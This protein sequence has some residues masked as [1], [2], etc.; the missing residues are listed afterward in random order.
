MFE[1]SEFKDPNKGKTAPY[2]GVSISKDKIISF[3]NMDYVKE[4]HAKT[5]CL[6]SFDFDEMR[7]ADRGGANCTGLCINSGNSCPHRI[8][9]TTYCLTLDEC[10]W[11]RIPITFDQAKAADIQVKTFHEQAAEVSDR[12]R[13]AMG[14][15]YRKGDRV[16]VTFPRRFPPTCAVILTKDFEYGQQELHAIHDDEP[17]L[18]QSQHWER[19]DDAST[20]NGLFKVQ[21]PAPARE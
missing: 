12:R 5:L 10:E 15:S 16:L 18:G 11:R 1:S 6:A 3:L 2:L 7:R 19:G 13:K 17:V 14:P 4:T 8:T 20:V 9:N 21:G